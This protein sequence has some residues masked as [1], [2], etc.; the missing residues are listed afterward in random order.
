MRY[1]SY[2]SMLLFASAPASFDET[3]ESAQASIP[4][5]LHDPEVPSV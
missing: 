4:R 5:L 3:R 1:F 2:V